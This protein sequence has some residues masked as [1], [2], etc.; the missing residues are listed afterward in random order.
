MAASRLR[1]FGRKRRSR[2][3]R[4]EGRELWRI[5][6]SELG[7]GFRVLYH[8]STENRV[9]RPEQDPIKDER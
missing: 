1:R 5:L 7:P 4:A 8:S 2:G 3:W 9:L 6:R